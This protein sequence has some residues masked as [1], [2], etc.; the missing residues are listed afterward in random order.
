MAP[1]NEDNIVTDKEIVYLPG[2][3]DGDASDNSD[4]TG[5]GGE[6]ENADAAGPDAEGATE[7]EGD[8]TRAQERLVRRQPKEPVKG[9]N[10]GE[11][12]GETE[13]TPKERA[14]RHEIETLR[15]NMRRERAT[16][17][18]AGGEHAETKP[19]E[20]APEKAAILKKY[21][22]EAI[23][24]FRDVLP[25]I[26]EDMGFVRAEELSAKTYKDQSE[27]E[28]DDFLKDHPE[29]LVANDK[30]NVLWNRFKS[31]FQMYRPPQHPKE[32]RKIFNRI[33]TDIFGIK[34]AGDKG[35]IN[36]QQ[37]KIKVASH[38]GA[39][40]P[41]RQTVSTRPKTNTAGLRLDALKGFT[42]DEIDE[43][44]GGAE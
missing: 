8:Q 11:S 3:R 32:Y 6:A 1:D 37:Q 40:G 25:V 20:L 30:E 14:L 7:G 17:L 38:A 15:A 19:K 33:H 43:M 13:D 16:E 28:L 34:P 24:A 29:Y 23:A 18:N 4:D 22:P 36:A 9:A 5:E 26:A 2:S 44:T 27:Q 41:A 12:D 31:E 42:Q 39:S 10:E 21:T 35:A